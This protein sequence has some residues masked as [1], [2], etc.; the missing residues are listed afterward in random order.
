MQTQE[1]HTAVHDSTGDWAGAF[2]QAIKWTTALFVKAKG[3]T[4]NQ[5]QSAID[6][7]TCQTPITFPT[8]SH[9]LTAAK[10][11]AL[12]SGERTLPTLP[13]DVCRNT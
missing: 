2:D 5:V 9:D 11:L 6:A 4:P 12:C 8:L 3:T 7:R 10:H 1:I 13:A